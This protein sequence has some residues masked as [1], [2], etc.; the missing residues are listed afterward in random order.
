MANTVEM[1][2]VRMRTQTQLFIL[3]THAS[4]VRKHWAT[5][6]HY[7]SLVVTGWVTRV[8]SLIS[9]LCLTPQ[10]G[11]ITGIMRNLIGLT[12]EG[13]CH[14]IHFLLW[15]ALSPHCSI[16]CCPLLLFQS[17][18]CFSESIIHLLFRASQGRVNLTNGTKFEISNQSA[19][20]RPGLNS[21]NSPLS[22][23]IV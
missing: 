10:S 17:L 20:V 7:E 9:W 21:T 23:S 19:P 5:N 16:V 2:S 8:S 15:R 6:H 14:A 22:L 3:I 4:L 13:G 12:E 18:I 1:T 11:K